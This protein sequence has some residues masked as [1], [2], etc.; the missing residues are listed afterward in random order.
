MQKENDE[1]AKLCDAKEEQSMVLA[2]IPQLPTHYKDQMCLLRQR[3]PC[4]RDII[5]QL[6]YIVR[7]D[8]H[9]FLETYSYPDTYGL[10]VL[11]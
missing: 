3:R 9:A 5:E 10:L 2:S 11:S 7:S 8:S 4:F 6:K 1:V